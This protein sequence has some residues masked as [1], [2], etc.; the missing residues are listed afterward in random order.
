MRN[1]RAASAVCASCEN[2]PSARY[3]LRVG[4]GF[5]CAKALLADGVSRQT[6]CA[7]GARAV[8]SVRAHR[9]TTARLIS[10][11]KL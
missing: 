10:A 6:R 7:L 5:S 1:V 3:P 9:A 2:V 4:I 8:H 11:K